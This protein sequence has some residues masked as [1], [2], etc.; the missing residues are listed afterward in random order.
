MTETKP[1][2]IDE[3]ITRF[4]KETQDILKQIRTTIK[5]II[6][7]AEETISYGIPTFRLN[8]R[9]LIYFAGFKKHIG[10]YPVPGGSKVFDKLF[11]A[12]K[13]S[14]KGT[15]QFALDKPIPYGLI[16]KIVTYRVKENSKKTKSKESSAKKITRAK[17]KP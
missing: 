15:I 12:Y 11:S 3:Y 8:G 2:D 14:G 13:T 5:N 17:P 9:Y 4:P 1:K 16:A 10:L 7:G 6:P